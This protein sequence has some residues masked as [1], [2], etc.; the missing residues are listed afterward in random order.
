MVAAV[1]KGKSQR[2]VA[3]QFRVSLSHVQYWVKRAGGAALEQVDWDD[4]PHVA[5]EV[6]NKTDL[7]IEGQ[8][9]ALRQQLQRSDLGFIGAQAIH[10]ALPDGRPGVVLPSVRTID[11]I[12]QRQGLLGSTRRVRRA[13]PPPGWYLPALAAGRVEL[14]ACD[15]VED[16]RIEGGPLVDVLTSRALW[17]PVCGV[18][19]AEHVNAA[20]I[21]EVLASHWDTY[22]LPAFAQFDNDT[23][24]QGGHNH[25][26][27]LGR[28]TR[29]CLSLGV[30]PVFAPPAEHGFQNLN[31][32]FNSLWQAKVWGRFHHSS[33]AALG[34]VSDRFTRAYQQHRARRI[35]QA[36]P[37]RPFPKSWRLDLQAR[38]HGQVIFLRR[39]DAQGRVEVL[40]H[41][42]SVDPAWLHRLVR[43]QVDLDHNHICFY[44]LRRN[45]PAQQPL[46]GTVPYTWP[47]R[48]FRDD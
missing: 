33:V 48:R 31:E 22:G 35:E 25:P 43:A 23:R 41:G 3:R 40:G 5:H 46:A 24:F 29:F 4:R 13:A 16:L 18:W 32:S 34:Q 39:T 47:H 37:R 28:V 42:W 45:E 9:V 2:A 30:T 19:P 10:E 8:V 17:G 15:V 44:R 14:D 20:F 21:T 12:L 1:R 7:A 27:V 38:P 11:R 6:A 26:D 36:P